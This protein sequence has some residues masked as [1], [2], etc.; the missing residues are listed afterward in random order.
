[1]QFLL[2]LV[3][4]L[5]AQFNLTDTLPSNQPDSASFRMERKTEG[6]WGYALNAY[7]GIV[8]KGDKEI[9]RI[10]KHNRTWT[11]GAQLRH[12]AL[13]SDGSAYDEDFNYPTFSLGF[14]YNHYQNVDFHRDLGN[15]DF[16]LAEPVDY[17]S[18]LG[19]TL[20]L[21][22]AFDRPLLRNPRKWQ[23][24]YTL[25]FGIG[26]TDKKY[27]PYNN[28]DNEMISTRFLIYC[29]LGAYATYS[30]TPELALRTGVEFQHHSNGALNRPNK[31]SNTI[32]P[33]V[34][35]VYRP[36]VTEHAKKE[37]DAWNSASGSSGGTLSGHSMTGEE[38]FHYDYINITAGVGAKALYEDWVKTQFETP[39]GDPDYR[40]DHFKAYMAYSLR[41]DYMRRWSRRW[42]TGAGLDVLYGSYSDH[43]KQIDEEEG[44]QYKHT[45]WSIGIGIKNETYY[46]RLSCAVS[47]GLYL[48]RH[49]GHSARRVEQP[50]Y[51]TIGLRYTTP[52]FNGL[53]VGFNVKAHAFK[54]DFTEAVVS[55]PIRLRVKSR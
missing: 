2:S 13:P 35:L 6:H 33:M 47:F 34:G 40:T 22:G 7:Y 50:F 37:D 15:Y 52:L 12:T 48:D 26:Y 53:Q 25:Q 42:A 17:M 9:K 54:A 21:Y 20:T 10:V 28:V 19:N 3:L 41:M 55:L 44:F 27:N 31:G 18:Y 14:N 16:G 24:Y 36:F 51:E 23:F 4:S 5:S 43:V 8:P 32:G 11:V 49:M 1:M 39:K 38:D 45:P 30:L 46:K 29:G